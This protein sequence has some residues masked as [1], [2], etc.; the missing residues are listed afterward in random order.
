MKNGRQIHGNSA[1]CVLI[2][3]HFAVHWIAIDVH[4]SVVSKFILNST[5]LDQRSKLKPLLSQRSHAQNYL[6]SSKS[7]QQELLHSVYLTENLSKYSAC[8]KWTKTNWSK[9]FL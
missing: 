8:D 6:I 2:S 5:I 1:T 9:C 3:S 4:V 7:K